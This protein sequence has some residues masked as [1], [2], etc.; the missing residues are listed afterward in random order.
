MSSV[1]FSVSVLLSSA[2]VQGERVNR[3]L[4]ERTIGSDATDV[5]LGPDGLHVYYTAVAAGGEVRYR[6]PTAGGI[7]TPSGAALGAGFTP[8][9]SRSFVVTISTDVNPVYFRL[10]SARTDGSAGSVFL[11]GRGGFLQYQIAPDSRYVLVRP[12][13]TSML[14][15]GSRAEVDLGL[16]YGALP[17]ITPDSTL[18][19][20]W[21]DRSLYRVPIDGSEAS[22][23]LHSLSDPWQFEGPVTITP[24]ST[25]ALF[26]V[27]AISARQLWSIRVDG[28]SAPV[29][30][31]ELGAVYQYKISP[32]SSQV[33]YMSYDSGQET[34][35]S[36]PV[37]G[38]SAPLQISG[39]AG[40]MVDFELTGD[41]LWVVYIASSPLHDE[42]YSTRVNGSTGPRK[43]NRVLPFGGDVTAFDLPASGPF[44][45]YRADQEVDQRFELYSASVD[46]STSTLRIGGENP[47]HADVLEFQV[48]PSGAGVYFRI[49]RDADEAYQLFAVG[50]EG[51]EPPLEVSGPRVAGGSVQPGW[52]LSPSDGRVVF[53][54]DALI[55]EHFQLFS[56]SVSGARVLLSDRARGS[57]ARF[58]T[59]P[60][61]ERALY[62]ADGTTPGR[63]E[64]Y[65]AAIDGP[66]HAPRLNPPAA[67]IGHMALLPDGSRAL[68]RTA[69]SGEI[70]SVPMDG[71]AEAVLLS[72]D[73]TAY[74]LDVAPDGEHAVF[75]FL[76]S[77]A[78]KR[79]LF[80][81]RVEGSLPKKL[82]PNLTTGLFLGN[83]YALA[84]QRAVFEIYSN[85]GTSNLWSALIAGGQPAVKLGTSP[86]WLSRFERFVATP[87]GTR[88][89]YVA[90][91]D[92]D[93]VFELYSVPTDNSGPA[94]KVSAP[95]VTGGDVNNDLALTPDSRHAIYSADATVDGLVEIFSA[96]LGGT[97]PT[98]FLART[99]TQG[100]HKT[101]DTHVIIHGAVLGPESELTS[102][103]IDG[104]LPPN[105]L[106]EPLSSGSSIGADFELVPGGGLVVFRLTTVTH[107]PTLLRSPI[108]ASTPPLVLED[109]REVADFVVSPD[110]SAVAYRARGGTEPFALFVVPM[111]G[112]PARRASTDLVAGG[113]LYVGDLEQPRGYAFSSDGR[114][115]LYL[116]DQEQDGIRELFFTQLARPLW[117][118]R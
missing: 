101:T 62:L 109:Q 106:H 70:F 105:R 27:R 61:A 15:D 90:D 93:E 52:A 19:L 49:D 23:V 35:F 103:P 69:D 85:T 44:V 55:D 51:T 32:D 97:G 114:R 36:V 100:A 115:L 29:L 22:L 107:A 88:V 83:T 66:N 56:T 48:D 110:G 94:V 6:V 64:A 59:T 34:L 89:V 3:P 87:D 33:V 67:E 26:V 10:Y 12:G 82:N 112:G 75:L 50:F 21:E 63:V 18:V 37:D 68:L 73:G 43:L 38:S 65:S 99:G 98:V 28:S 92:T 96:P 11:A 116:A 16:P 20:A 30:L 47:P 74:S 53:V 86:T 1:G 57:V 2:L 118:T 111:T 78:L 4:T 40:E 113:S 41:G 5:V 108:D 54:A 80:S 72:P 46:G 104:S 8:D 25:R 31:A 42:L 17:T 13:P 60:G 79:G 58:L 39:A 71:S 95:L 91:R 81:A 24:D 7:S 77:S 14:V 76:P 84:G 102:V 45:A 117:R 9:G